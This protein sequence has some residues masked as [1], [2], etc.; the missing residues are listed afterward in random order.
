LYAM[1]TGRPPFRA[2]T[3]LAVIKRVCEDTPKSVD[4]INAK[5][6]DWLVEIIARLH[7]KKPADRFQ[8][9]PGG[10][11]L[12]APHLQPLRAPGTAKKPGRPAPRKRGRLLRI[13]LA[14]VLIGIAIL[15]FLTCGTLAYLFF[16]QRVDNDDDA[17]LFQAGKEPPIEE[18]L[19]DLDSNDIF[20]R[21]K[22]AKRLAKMKP[23]QRRE[24]VAEKLGEM[25]E[26]DNPHLRGNAIPAL[27]VWATTKEVPILIKSLDNKDVFTR[28]AA[29]QVV[30]SFHDDRAIAPMVRC[31]QDPQTRQD[32]GEALRDFGPKAEKDVLD[33]LDKGDIFVQQD[34][35]KVLRDIGTPA[36]V[37]RLKAAAAS[38]NVFVAD[39]ARD[40]LRAI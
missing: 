26:S 31:F 7:A 4:D 40:A 13:A 16:N 21:M 25:A 10:A 33:L 15:P 37:A 30:G 32:A 8:S 29:L 20:R 5:T 24:E 1:C 3:T 34:A 35:I 22:A 12:L 19:D 23:K 17:H 36:S 27:G 9:A 39:H 18:V 2:P 11:R 6:P 28:R 38:E 14:F